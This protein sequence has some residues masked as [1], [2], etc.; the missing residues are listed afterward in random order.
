[1]AIKNTELLNCSI[2]E[3]P[4]KRVLRCKD[5]QLKIGLCRAQIYSL[6]SEGLFPKPISL[7]KRASGWLE[8]EIDDWLDERIAVSRLGNSRFGGEAK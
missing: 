4:Y 2:D 5:V 8:H 6:V 1:M 7:G 3:N